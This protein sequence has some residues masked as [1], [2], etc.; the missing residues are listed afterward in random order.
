MIRKLTGSR[1][2]AL[3]RCQTQQEF[4][5]DP[6]IIAIAGD[7]R[8]DAELPQFGIDDVPAIAAFICKHVGLA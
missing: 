6:H 7:Q 2:T 3:P 4:P 8:V 5:Q 1:A